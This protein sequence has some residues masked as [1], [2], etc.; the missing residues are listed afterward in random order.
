[1]PD[2]AASGQQTRVGAEVSR[3][4]PP[5][6]S[7]SLLL[8]SILLIGA[9]T[10]LY[11]NLFALPHTPFLLGG[12]QVYFWMDAQRM[13]DGKHIY[14][15]FIQFT[16][17]GTDLLYAALF[18]LFGFHIWVTNATV[19][20]LGVTFCWLSF[21]LASEIMDRRA[22]LLATALFLVFIY[23][24][25]MNGT[26]HWFS[27]LA[28]MGAVKIA[29]TKITS[30][31]ITL[32]GALLG[33]AS[34]FSQTHGA[35]GM[36]AFATFLLW[37]KLLTKSSLTDLLK[38]QA[39]LFLGF[40]VVFLLLNAHFIATIG[41][42]QLWYFQVTYVTKYVVDLSQGQSIGLPGHL[43]WR[44]LPKLSPY[45]AVYIS[46]PVVY[47][48]TLWRCW[49]ERRNPPYPW[50][51]IALLSTV[52]LFLLAEVA[53][54]LNWLRL[55]AI[56]I[57]G[58]ILLVWLI[59]RTPKIRRFTMALLWIGIIGL[60][61][62]QTISGHVS[63]SLKADLPGGRAATSPQT[64]EK[65]HWI[66][67]RT[68]PGDFFFQAGWPGMYLPLQLRNPLYLDTLGMVRASRPQ[69]TDQVIQQLNENHVQ[70]ILWT[71][72]LDLN[73]SPDRRC[74]DYLTPFRDYLRSTYVRTRVFPDGDALWQ[75]T[76]PATTT[77]PSTY[78]PTLSIAAC[79][80]GAIIAYPFAFGCTPSLLNPAFIPPLSSAIAE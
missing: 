30:Q 16:P 66:A 8:L 72:N 65:L 63:Q 37:K 32:A 53:R 80:S 50:D 29:F 27:V 40:A 4:A 58:I 59:D 1:M 19:L 41:L 3:T 35:A 34:F 12:D 39:Q 13:L 69:D 51:R 42:K 78:P 2:T 55:Y 61:A 14:Q 54:S 45:L 9:A 38:M 67:Q 77:T 33:L 57:P 20:I 76:E 48:L 75:R 44:T 22:A 49:R 71:A 24:K 25:A 6:T 64:Y 28:V 74:E 5:K 60:A 10:Y 79:A 26:H 7:S 11:L 31:R 18:K 43:T 15:D 47:L 70:F 23:G 36:L 46:L 21:S 62:H 52:G 17:P 56:S 68:K 73:C